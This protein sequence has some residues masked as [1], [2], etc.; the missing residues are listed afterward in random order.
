MSERYQRHSL[1]DW[2]DQ[3][4]LQEA[5]VIVV[6]AGAVGNEVLKKD[7]DG[8][9]F[10]AAYDVVDWESY[11][12]RLKG[13][14]F[15]TWAVEGGGILSFGGPLYIESGEFFSMIGHMSTVEE[16]WLQEH[17]EFNQVLHDIHVETAEQMIDHLLSHDQR[18]A[19]SRKP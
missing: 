10:A 1:I 19:R 6:G 4:R 8:V 2:F 3:K 14:P 15:Y 17:P 12:E 11:Y 5:Q 7:V 18:S 16:G 13:T 9:L